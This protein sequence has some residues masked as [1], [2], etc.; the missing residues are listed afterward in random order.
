MSQTWTDNC[1][2]AAGVAQTDMQNIEN[3]FAAIKSS[4]SGTSVPSF[5]LVG[6]M[7][8][9]DQDSNNDSSPSD[10][11]MLK[12]RKYDNT[13]WV[14]VLLGDSSQKMWVYRNDCGEG[15]LIDSSVTDRVIALKG[16]TN[17]YNV[18]G[19]T[20]PPAST[21]TQPNHTHTAGTIGSLH[22]HQIYNSSGNN[23]TDDQYYDSSGAAQDFG[24]VT[25]APGVAQTARVILGAYLGNG[26]SEPTPPD[27]YTGIAAADTG[28]TAGS[29]TAATYRPA[30]AVGTLQYPDTT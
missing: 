10:H 18:N 1:F 14:N 21:W 4:F 28:T 7:L 3:N 25:K 17:A 29:A 12:V 6:G 20:S 26:D 5:T 9:C 19:G 8:W 16:G 2:N 23:N 27:M 11:T 30:A 13:G 22:V 24:Y 15:W